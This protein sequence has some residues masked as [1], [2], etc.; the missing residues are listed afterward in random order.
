MTAKKLLE[1]KLEMRKITDRCITTTLNEFCSVKHFETR[2]YKLYMQMSVVNNKLKYCLNKY[3]YS[4][5]S[6]C[7]DPGLEEITGLNEKI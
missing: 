5:K 1:M 3:Y 4:L 2:T 7:K 6:R